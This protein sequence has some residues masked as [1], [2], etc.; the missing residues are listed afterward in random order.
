MMVQ[1]RIVINVCG[2]EIIVY[3]VP[4]KSRKH[5]EEARQAF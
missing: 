2:T 5:H 4:Q 3:R 1:L